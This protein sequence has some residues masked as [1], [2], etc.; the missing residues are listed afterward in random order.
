[1]SAKTSPQS[2]RLPSA[3]RTRR[4][5]GAGAKLASTERILFVD[6][7]ENALEGFKRSMRGQFE[8][9]TAGGGRR[10]LAAIQLSGPY[11]I[12]ISDMRM[13]EMNGAQFLQHVRLLHPNTVRMLLTG[14]RDLDRAI[15]AVN[16]GY[17]FRYLTK[18]CNKEEIVRAIFLGL[19]E[20][21]ANVEQYNLAKEAQEIALYLAGLGQDPHERNPR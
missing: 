14:H 10:G 17:I 13:P 7:E 16:E 11:A 4:P 9:D 1:M 6:D 2:K 19:A 8:V 18:P 3:A 5:A 20:Y 15:D 12:V 21:R